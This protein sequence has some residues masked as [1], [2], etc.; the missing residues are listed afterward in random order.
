MVWANGGFIV[1]QAPHMLFLR[2]TNAD[3]RADERKILFS[4]FG[5]FDTHAGP[6]NLHYGF[7]NWIWG[8]V[9]YSGF[10][11]KGTMDKDSSHFGQALFRFKAYGSHIEYMT[12]T[13][14]NTWGMAQNEVGDVF[15]STAN[16]SH[17]WYM[18]L[19]HRAYNARPGSING[20][21][22]TD[23][24]KDMK[25]ITDKVRQVDVF[26]G[27]TAA[28]GHNFYTARAFPKAYWNQM[29]FVCEPTGHIVHLNRMQKNGT[30]YE[31]I[32]PASGTGF[33]LMAGADEWFAPV[34][35][36][37]GP[38]GAVW[39][40]DWYSY[41]IQHNPTPQGFQNGKG[42]AYDTDLRDFSHGRIYRVG[43]DNAPKPN[44]P[45]LD[46]NN[47]ATLIATLRNDNQFWRIR[48]QRLLVE[49]GN[50]DVAP[51]LW[52]IANDPQV[53]EIGINAPA[54]HALWTL[55]GL[56]AI[57]LPELEKA[58]KHPCA[59]V[60]KTAVQVMPRTAEGA[61]M[62]LAQRTL[63]DNEPLVVL[64]TLLALAES[65]RNPAADEAVLTRLRETTT[66][67][68]RWLPDAFAAALNQH[69]ARLLRQWLGTLHESRGTLAPEMHAGMD[70]SQHTQ[71]QQKSQNEAYRTAD[72]FDLMVDRVAMEPAS[73]MVRE[74]ARTTVYVKNV[75]DAPVAKGTV[76]ALTM[77]FE[78]KSGDA[79]KQKIDMV[80]Y[81]TDGI[82]A[83]ETVAITKT[84]NG[85]WTGDLRLTGDYA[86]EYTFS[87]SIDKEGK[88]GE[89]NRTN[90]THI[91]SLT[92][93]APARM[94]TV[95]LERAARAY[96][97]LAP[98]DSVAAMLTRAA[99]LG[100]ENANAFVKGLSDGYDYGKKQRASAAAGNLLASLNE[101]I[102]AESVPR[103]NRLLEAWGLRDA[104]ADLDPNTQLIKLKTVREEMRYDLTTFTVKAG[105]PVV[106]VLE[107]PDAMQHNLVVGKPKSLERIGKLADAMI[108]AKDGAERNYV[109]TTPDVLAATALINPN[110]TVRLAFKAP[111]QP[112][113]Y[114]YVCTFPGHWR[115]MKGVMKVVA[116]KPAPL[117]VK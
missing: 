65:P 2:D 92:V 102:P 107:N 6:S 15:G 94:Q 13:S 112:G 101:A 75:G 14:N 104:N 34:H 95:A 32:E 113:E 73:P 93:R 100:D 28:A 74:G 50:K 60:R 25:P 47:P 40:A 70:H 66:N 82:G 97:S 110:Q 37:V 69:N 53:D 55:H 9:G 41:I 89:V 30:D 26:G 67:D 108:T 114:P 1:S 80:S 18:A 111:D 19:P 21:R 77:R 109:P 71:A 68:D 27:F 83:G 54:I 86:G 76:V 3:D 45:V 36:E 4:G 38:D 44:V 24:H 116:D 7:D 51:L 29:A 85:P 115:L 78:G 35:A 5:T 33:N 23:T 72:G 57:T 61:T 56:G 16:N 105:K 43:Y 20:S 10:H 81:F 22:G 12:S 39:V 49:R 79:A 58:L 42:N 84:N 48:A 46:R 31:D 87:I 11:G 17:G 8:C 91:A 98:P 96:A 63:Y 52:A 103:L 88:L 99:D 117:G 62:L 64:Q 106:I 90:N 59:H